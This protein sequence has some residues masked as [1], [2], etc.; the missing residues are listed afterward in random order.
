[1]GYGDKKEMKKEEEYILTFKGL[2]SS[3]LNETGTQE[4]LD[5]VE[6]Y[7]RKFDYNAI[8]L[9]KDGFNFCKV[10]KK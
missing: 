5:M 2:L 9:E 10:E 8:I 6:L 3:K 1:M 4:I 7:M